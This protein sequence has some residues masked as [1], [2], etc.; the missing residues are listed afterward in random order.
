MPFDRVRSSENP[1]ALMAAEDQ[2]SAH[3]Q[4]YGGPLLAT[5][6]PPLQCLRGCLAENIARNRNKNK[7]VR[8]R[9]VYENKGNTDSMS[10]KSRTFSAKYRTFWSNRHGFCRKKGLGDDNL[11]TLSIEIGNS[12]LE[13]RNSP[14]DPI[15]RWSDEPMAR[16]FNHQSQIANHQW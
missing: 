3:P 7:Y 6:V 2:Q 14:D 8:S 10:E 12:K 5:E 13:T 9:N 15:A 16:C 4:R 1:A 11:P